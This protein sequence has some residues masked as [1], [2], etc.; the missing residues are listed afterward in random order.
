MTIVQE[1]KE[2]REKSAAMDAD[3]AKMRA[4]AD[5]YKAALEKVTAELT[6]QVKAKDAEVLAV[7][8]ELEK[9]AVALAEAQ[10]A[11]KASADK[12]VELEAKMKL[13]PFADV[14][15]G[16]KPV[17]DGGAAAAPEGSLID[18]LQALGALTP[19]G[20]AFYRKHEKEIDALKKRGQ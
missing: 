1:V 12:V 2:L 9:S 18:Q 7:K 16:Q 13:A 8:A 4:C 15:A 6:E 5:E 3:L 10:K 20:I 14:S 11:G 19:A 17:A